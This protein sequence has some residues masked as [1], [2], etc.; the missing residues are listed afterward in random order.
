[1]K[2]YLGLLAVAALLLASC[3][4][5]DKNDDAND[6]NDTTEQPAGTS[7]DD[8]TDETDDTE[9]PDDEGS[10]S[11]AEEGAGADGSSGLAAARATIVDGGFTCDGELETDLPAEDSFDGPQPIEMLDCSQE[12]GMFLTGFGWA[13]EDDA[14][15]GISAMTDMFCEAG[16]PEFSYI[17][18][19]DWMMT[20]M[21][22][23][24]ETEEAADVLLF[25]MAGTLDDSPTIMPC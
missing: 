24:P 16:L 11:G 2:R 12:D 10:E 21:E 9:A 20:M 22:V 19:S 14:G 4:S 23:T 15:E 6:A 8:D 7:G 5:D 17:S 18:G 3:G 25:D 1:M 13:S